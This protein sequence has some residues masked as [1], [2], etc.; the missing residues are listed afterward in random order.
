M[1]DAVLAAGKTITP[2]VMNTV[3]IPGACSGIDEIK[4]DR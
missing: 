2:G 3:S 1:P 4:A